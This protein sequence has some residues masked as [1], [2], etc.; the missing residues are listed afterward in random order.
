MNTLQNFKG[1]KYFL[2]PIVVVATLV[3]CSTSRKQP[4]AENTTAAAAA[5]T[6][7]AQ[8][9]TAEGAKTKRV[10]K[11]AA[12]PAEA[13]TKSAS[14]AILS[15]IHQADQK[16]IALGNI[17][18]DKASTVEVQNYAK[19]LVEDHTGAD[20]QVKAMAQKMN[21]HLFDTPSSKQGRLESAKLKS[22]AG[23]AF[24]RE[25]L[26][27]TSAD[28]DKLIRELKQERED[29]SDDDIEALIDKILPILEQHQQLAQIL[30]KKE[31]A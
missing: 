17:A 12:A 9:T 27:Q 26:R 4:S 10:A 14:A 19:Q 29:A 15:Q 2:I 24:D 30:L 3:G 22:A 20:Q 7:A 6:P 28:H 21:V 13:S 1:T 11:R 16:E 23:P 25:F 8:P 5:A 31:Q 18:A